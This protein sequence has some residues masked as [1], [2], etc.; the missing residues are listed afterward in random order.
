MSFCNT[1]QVI[2]LLIFEDLQQSTHSNQWVSQD[3]CSWSPKV[4][5]L[6]S[7]SLTSAAMSFVTPVA[8]QPVSCLLGALRF[9]NSRYECNTVGSKCAGNQCQWHWSGGHLFS[10]SPSWHWFSVPHFFATLIFST[11]SFLALITSELSFLALISTTIYFQG[12]DF[13]YVKFPGT[14]FQYCTFSGHWFPVLHA[15]GTLIFSTYMNVYYL[16]LLMTLSS[17]LPTHRVQHSRPQQRCSWTFFFFLFWIPLIWSHG[18]WQRCS[19]HH[20]HT[21]IHLSPVTTTM[22]TMQWQW[23]RHLSPPRKSSTTT[24]KQVSLMTL[25]LV[26]MYSWRINKWMYDCDHQIHGN[27]G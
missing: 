8:E 21:I 5:Q 3:W 1:S 7:L 10:V 24:E 25:M 12:T 27:V 2:V 9:F 23:R 19:S 6:L 4:L 13:Q 22:A 26:M 16:L 15:F 14:D 18:H 17:L 20:H 11:L